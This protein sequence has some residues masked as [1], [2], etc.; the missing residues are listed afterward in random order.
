MLGGHVSCI[1]QSIGTLNTHVK[2]GKAR[3]LMV[4]DVNRSSE[5]PD[6]PTA[7]EK[8]Y[9]VDFSVWYSLAARKGTPKLVLDSLGKFFKQTAG[10]PTV[11]AAL[12]K[13]G[14]IPMN[15]SPEEAEKRANFEFERASEIFGKLGLLVK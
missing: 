2:A 7:K 10:D 5:V 12:I 4:F 1:I 6:V 11:Q 8:G 15:L 13:A 3:I 14:M 9:N